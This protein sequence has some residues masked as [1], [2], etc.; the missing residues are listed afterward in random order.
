MGGGE[1]LAVCP[2]VA[3][4]VVSQWANDD[5]PFRCLGNDFLVVGFVSIFFIKGGV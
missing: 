4:I 2:N 1:W 3:I 5:V